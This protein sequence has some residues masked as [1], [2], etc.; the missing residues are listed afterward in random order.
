MRIM[1]L[2]DLRS[3]TWEL[4]SPA[5]TLRLPK[6]LRLEP[7]FSSD[8]QSR[9]VPTTETSICRLALVP[10]LVNAASSGPTEDDNHVPA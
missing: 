6:L 8:E 2:L 4:T 7:S 3:T 10:S 9:R 1:P 5:L